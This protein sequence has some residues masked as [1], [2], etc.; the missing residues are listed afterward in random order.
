MRFDDAIETLSRIK[1]FFA[2]W[3]VRMEDAGSV[4]RKSAFVNDLELVVVPKMIP[5]PDL[6]GE[7]KE[8][9]AL[10]NASFKNL[11]EVVRNGSRYKRINLEKISLDLFIVMPP[12]QW[13]V[14]YALRTGDKFFSH[15]LVTKKIGYSYSEETQR[16]FHGALPNDCRVDNGGVYKNDVLIPTPDEIDF[17]KIYGLE[18]I[19]PP[20]RNES[21]VDE[22]TRQN[23]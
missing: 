3:C 6:F 1:D 19:E 9:S 14:I 15:W 12:A 21:F 22:W 7:G 17:F 11:G 20:N 10:D 5:S 4:R 13:G 23:K 18:Y 2:P 16:Y 8:Y